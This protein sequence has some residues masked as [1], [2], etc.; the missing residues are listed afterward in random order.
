MRKV[1]SLPLQL[2]EHRR[3]GG[4]SSEMIILYKAD[5]PK[6]FLENYKN[7]INSEK[8]L[9][10]LKKTE[11]QKKKERARRRKMQNYYRSKY[12]RKCSQCNKLFMQELINDLR[13]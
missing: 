1:K 13:K 12:S 4:S 5:I 10:T 3:N 8:M 6:R 7:I 11:L 2:K 9:F